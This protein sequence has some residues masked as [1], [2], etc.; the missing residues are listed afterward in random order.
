MMNY[1]AAIEFC[2]EDYGAGDFEEDYY[3]EKE[4]DEF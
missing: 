3:G 4:R 2:G 1:Y